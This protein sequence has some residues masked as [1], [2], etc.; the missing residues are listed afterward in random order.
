MR[1]SS[2]QAVVQS[3]FCGAILGIGIGV[4]AVP[5]DAASAD[6]NLAP[7][8]KPEP[9]ATAPDSAIQR[10]SDVAFASGHAPAAGGVMLRQAGDMAAPALGAVFLRPATPDMSEAMTRPLKSTEDEGLHLAVEAPV[11]S[12]GDLVQGRLRA[13]GVKDGA[14]TYGDR[15]RFYLFAAVRGQAVGMN[16][17]SVAGGGLHRDGWSSDTSSALVGD[18]QLGI[19]WRKGGMEA[20]FGYVHRGVHIQNAPRG[21][22]D[23]YADDMAAVSLTFRP[24]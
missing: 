12:V 15:G 16:L 22:S 17:V 4:L 9:K 10:L 8:Y 18:G 1:S 2:R 7:M 3:G 11:Q 19:G 14:A 5:A 6:L 21:A 23:S 20:D 13:M 24:H